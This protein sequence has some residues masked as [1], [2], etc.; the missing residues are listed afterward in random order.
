MSP[1][2]PFPVHTAPW[3]PPSFS[4]SPSSAAQAGQDLEQ[5]WKGQGD[6]PTPSR[7]A[8]CAHFHF[9]DAGQFSSVMK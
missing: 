1:S 7:L 6:A 2:D 9:Q 3:L 8:G 4:Q 5:E